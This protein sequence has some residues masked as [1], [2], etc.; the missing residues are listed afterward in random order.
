MAR[1]SVFIVV[2]L[3]LFALYSCQIVNFVELAGSRFATLDDTPAT[4][5]AISSQTAPLALPLGWTLAANSNVTASAAAS[6]MWGTDCLVLRDGS[7]VPSLSGASCSGS[8]LKNDGT[9]RYRPLQSRI[10]IA[11]PTVTPSNAGGKIESSAFTA[12]V[13]MGVAL[14]LV[15]AGRQDE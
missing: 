8:Q 10:F 15:Y 2:V 11:Q 4:R 1:S 6:N 5:S 14:F 12:A 7:A 13:C 9:G 3:S